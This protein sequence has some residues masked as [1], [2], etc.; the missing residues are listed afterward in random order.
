MDGEKSVLRERQLRG[1]TDLALLPWADVGDGESQVQP[2]VA[3]ALAGG[4]RAEQIVEALSRRI[5]QRV[6]EELLAVFTRKDPVPRH[7]SRI[8]VAVAQEKAEAACDE[9][10][11]EP[12]RGVTSEVVTCPW[13]GARVHQHGLQG[14]A[15]GEDPPGRGAGDQE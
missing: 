15:R 4:H 10:R 9:L 3:A 14:S 7:V 11:V 8:D 5:G 12:T 13:D 6:Q 2:S 1:A